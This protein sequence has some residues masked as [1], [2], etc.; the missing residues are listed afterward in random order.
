MKFLVVGLGSAGQRHVRNLRHLLGDKAK[1]SVWRVRGLDL[2][3]DNQL[4][5]VFGRRPEDAYALTVH[6]TLDEA[7]EGKPDV[8]IV[9]NPISEHLRIGIAAIK[10]GCHVFI[11]KPLSHSWD[12]VEE[13]L[14]M[15][16]SQGR[17]GYVGYQM[18]F[19]PGL[20][21]VKRSVEDG[22]IGKVISAHFHYGEY[23]P[24]MH[25]YED[26][27][28]SHAA[29]LDQGGGV[30]RALSH[31]L[32]TAQWLFG[33]PRRVFAFGG[34]LSGLEIDVEDTAAIVLECGRGGRHFP[35]SVYLDFV[36]QPPRRTCEVVGERGTIRWDYYDQSV[37]YYD[38][39]DGQWRREV[40][41]GFE[42]NQLFL[43]EMTNFLQAIEGR[44]EP[45]IPLEEGAKTLK[46]ILAAL[47][48]LK[49]GQTVEVAG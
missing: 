14:G 30:I 46:I 13:L 2:V 22:L 42:R 16:R 7:L 17:I 10:A 47:G 43:D 33:M 45:V 4:N 1:I 40:L 6:K 35:V 26:Y 32:D 3:L 37:S 24:G 20:R 11:E 21:M 44:E 5:A 25:P 28:T 36:Q 8:V 41:K 38:P 31:D 19:H 39:R 48:S 12:G 9:A 34:H 23:L 18:R 49:T 15:T 29:R 27:R